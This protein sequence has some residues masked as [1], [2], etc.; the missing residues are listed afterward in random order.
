MKTYI[1]VMQPNTHTVNKYSLLKISQT[2]Q[3]NLHKASESLKLE[4]GEFFR[5]NYSAKIVSSLNA[6]RA[7]KLNCYCLRWVG[8]MR[9]CSD[10]IDAL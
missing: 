10:V 7:D 2:I 1:D 3:L 4:S 8:G 5:R 9:R 6:K